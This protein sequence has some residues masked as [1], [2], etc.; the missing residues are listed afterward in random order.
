MMLEIYGVTEET[1]RDATPR[2]P[3]F[4]ISETPRFVGRAVVALAADPDRAR[5]NGQSLSSAGL[6]QAYGYRP[7]WLPA[8]RLPL[9]AGGAGEGEAGRR[10]RLPLTSF[11]PRPLVRQRREGLDVVALPRKRAMI[12]L[13]CPASRVSRCSRTSDWSTGSSHPARR[14]SMSI[15]LTRISL[16]GTSSAA[17]CPGRSSRRVR[18]TR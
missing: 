8:G 1:W 17:S 4:V 10:H 11:G 9:P 6:A 13:A 5:W 3:H 12:S 7:G 14:C 2:V 16:R 15:T 18:S